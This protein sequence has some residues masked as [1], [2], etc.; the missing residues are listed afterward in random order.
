MALRSSSASAAQAYDDFRLMFGA[1]RVADDPVG[2]KTRMEIFQKRSEAV[3]LHNSKAGISWTEEVNKF[4][5][6]TDSE[7]KALLGL[8]RQRRIPAVDFTFTNMRSASDQ[9]VADSQDWTVSLKSS[10]DVMDQG[11]CG[12]CWAVATAG[13]LETRAEI[14]GYHVKVSYHQLSDCTPNP[15]ECGGTGG[16]MGATAEAALNFTQTDGVVLSTHYPTVYS[17]SCQ[18]ASHQASLTIT[19]YN[20]VEPTNSATALLTALSEGPVAV[21]VDATNWFQYGGGIYAGCE[22]NAIINHAVLMVGYS[23]DYY[24][25]R[26]SWG[27]W[28]ETHNGKKGYIKLKRHDEGEYCGTDTAPLDGVGCALGDNQAGPTMKVCGM[29]GVLTDS[30]V[31]VG[32]T[33]TSNPAAVFQTTG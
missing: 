31:P 3:M 9:K 12:S 6:Y 30:A 18:T 2:L 17:D 22:K 5:D 11:S 10:N 19:G 20:T 28:G 16:C 33:V 26:N 32:L 7:L 21:S 4:T 25:I 23:A 8:R 27:S 24:L 15:D 29:C 1:Q 14:L 13:M